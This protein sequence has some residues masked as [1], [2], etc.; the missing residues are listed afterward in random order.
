MSS[1][2]TLLNSSYLDLPE[3]FYS[4]DTLEL[5]HNPNTRS[6]VIINGSLAN[7]LGI[8]PSEL[9]G[10]TPQ[11]IF[12]AS[13][14]PQH[15]TP[16]ALAY[17]GHQFGSF[18]P[19]LGDGRALMIGEL[20]APNGIRYD[21]QLKGSGRTHFSRRGDGRATL[22]PMLREYIIGEALHHLGIPATRTLAVS[23]TGEL[24]YRHAALPGAIQTRIAK[25]HIRVGTFQYAALNGGTESL[26]ALS[27]Y[28]IQR[29]YPE[30]AKSNEPYLE[31]AIAIIEA[32]ASLIAKWIGV[33][34]IHGVLNTDNVA[35]S[36]ESIDFGPCAFMNRYNP[37]AVY[38]SIDSGGRYAFGA[39]PAITEW[40]IARLI[41]AMLPLLCGDPKRAAEIGSQ[42][43]KHFSRSFNHRLLSELREKLGLFTEHEGD[44]E[45]INLLL[46]E[47]FNSGLDY[48][49]T[50]RALSGDEA[51]TTPIE[52]SQWCLAWKTRLSANINSRSP[53]ESLMA[54]REKNPAVIA[55]NHNVEAAITAALVEG[56]LT[57]VE[58]LVA[59]LR[60]PFSLATFSRPPFPHPTFAHQGGLIDPPPGGDDPKGYATFC[61]T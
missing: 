54:M 26:R 34:F 48:T 23:T 25:S 41:E 60:S 8:D 33:G 42:L 39:Q 10:T 6:V 27:D 13:E 52:L 12:T 38:S 37:R 44:S 14:L 20:L 55:R 56:D 45:L 61:G 50:F 58:K 5:T 32:Q 29:S 19:L 1:R 15:I 16:L 9:T 49:T 22:G 11:A 2:F 18:V 4:K 47:L 31:L 59:A 57:Q 30:V 24:V 35:I 7:D 17:S 43:T 3:V 46:K 51:F 53:E 28:V 21:L 40:N 36:G